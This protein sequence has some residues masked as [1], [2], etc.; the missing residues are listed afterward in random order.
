MRVI[1]LLVIA[2]FSILL[3]ALHAQEALPYDTINYSQPGF[4]DAGE[5]PITQAY[6]YGPIFFQN[7]TKEPIQVLNYAKSCPCLEVVK[8]PESIAPGAT[9]ALEFMFT[10]EAE[11]WVNLPINLVTETGEISGNFR[12]RV[13][14]ANP[15]QK[16]VRA[17]PQL[18]GGQE[19]RQALVSAADLLAEVKEKPSD[20]SR[21]LVDIRPQEDFLQMHIPGSVNVSLLEL[22]SQE[23][24]KQ[25]A[26]I[27]VDEGAMLSTH[28]TNIERLKAAGF[29]NVRWLAGGV[30]AWR[31]AGG[32]WY[33]INE[34]TPTLRALN[35]LQL[36]NAYARADFAVVNLDGVE[37]NEPLQA[38]FHGQ[39]FYDWFSF[40]KEHRAL[41]DK[42]DAEAHAQ[43]IADL[44]PL[45]L[46]SESEGVIINAA[47]KLM[48]AGFYRSYY[49]TATWQ[50]LESY[51]ETLGS[52]DEER[53]RFIFAGARNNKGKMAP[54]KITKGGCAD[55][56]Q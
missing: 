14:A 53:R 12:A 41:F 48:D 9:E 15:Y 22:L 21:M 39:D 38:L 26:I 10:P 33:G 3:P 19:A 8:V 50:E 23:H 5:I 2:A 32:E 25:K 46:Y 49:S 24:N 40:R 45:L 28:W 1:F 31:Q 29:E 35:M 52:S 18:T 42:E 27:I 47:A 43:A 51:L 20:W 30:F 34:S 44:K 56:P 4:T 13:T 37:A 55:C 11:G 17:W 6:W 7:T 36:A 16:L 54:V